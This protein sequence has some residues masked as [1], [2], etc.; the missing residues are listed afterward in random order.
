MLLSQG[1]AVGKRHCHVY[2]AYDRELSIPLTVR[3][4][5]VCLFEVSH[6]QL[7]IMIITK[8]IQANHLFSLNQK[9]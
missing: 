6:R 3:Q 1:S 4:R 5:L 8:S 7:T 9:I 2:I